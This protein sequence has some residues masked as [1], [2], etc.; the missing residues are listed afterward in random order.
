MDGSPKLDDRIEIVYARR[1]EIAEVFYSKLFVVLP[2]V[3]PYLY[4]DFE[5]QKKMFAMM[6]TMLAWTL[7]KEDGFDAYAAQLSE[8]H[9]RFD[10][11]AE[12]FL[13]GGA[14]LKTAIAEVL[15]NSVSLR[16]RIELNRAADRLVAAISPK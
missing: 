10:I 3:Q 11:T 9:S 8:A 14:V 16:D 4:P 1:D 12:Q 7:E 15:G 2:E 5:K 13:V 6:V